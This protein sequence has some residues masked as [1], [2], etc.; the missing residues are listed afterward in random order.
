MNRFL[1]Q[2]SLPLYG[3]VFCV[4]LFISITITS[5]GFHYND[6]WISAGQLHQ[7][8]TGHQIITNEGKYGYMPEGISNFFYARG[9]LF[10]YGLFLPV[11]ALPS[12]FLF[13]SLDTGFRFAIIF[14]WTILPI[15]V[16]LMILYFYPQY[17]KFHGISWPWIL[18]VLSIILFFLNIS[19]FYPF[20]A[21]GETDP[22]EA[23]ALIFTDHLVLACLAMVYL[24]INRLL[25][26][27]KFFSLFGTFSLL[28]SSSYIFWGSSA[29]DHI[30]VAFVFTVILASTLLMVRKKDLRYG[31]LTFTCC[32][33]LAWLRP[34]FALILSVISVC[35][36]Y[37]YYYILAKP[38][39]RTKINVLLFIPLFLLVGSIPFLVNNV[40]VSGN[41]LTP[42]FQYAVQMSES[43]GIEYEWYPGAALFAKDETETGNPIISLIYKIYNYY[44]PQ[45][46]TIFGDYYSVLFSDMVK[47]PNIIGVFAICPLF[48][49]GVVLL[50]LNFIKLFPD[51]KILSEELLI[52]LIFTASV[53]IAY[54]NIFPYLINNPGVNGP[55]YRHLSP[56]YAPATL[57]GLIAIYRLNNSANN[58]V[59]LFKTVFLSVIILL[60]VF[61]F[62]LL[63]FPIL[64]GGAG[65]INLMIY[66]SLISASIFILLTVIK[67]YYLIPFRLDYLVLGV[68]LT[69]PLL[70]NIWMVLMYS[71]LTINGYPLW[72]PYI[73]YL[74][75][76][77]LMYA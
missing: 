54:T 23:A 27:N 13:M 39:D 62:I 3:I 10:I 50:L 64:G 77:N 18:I 61:F 8:A 31:I 74:Y 22:I 21:V 45:L 47:N 30:L 48:F 14:L 52:C 57:L 69:I 19:Y 43:S 53:L 56:I 7:L 58:F 34:E 6:E 1:S 63:L 75:L 17:S 2:N 42:P 38:K 24:L 70:W 37:C 5:P 35:I 65:Y 41:P 68:M 76:D 46:D 33:L 59:N 15:F 9:N 36:Y 40:V 71:V 28:C 26:E 4:V 67:K 66:A 32:G 55:D 72:L 11:I 49:V 16:A 51:N 29:K 60:P 25:F 20:S 73:E 12:Y 44:T